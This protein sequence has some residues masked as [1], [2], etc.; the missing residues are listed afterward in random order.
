MVR[1]S[2]ERKYVLRSILKIR[3]VERRSVEKCT[4]G[5]CTEGR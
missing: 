5:E 3:S 4:E 2:V 1:S